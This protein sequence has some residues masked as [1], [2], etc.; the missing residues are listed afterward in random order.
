[1]KNSTGLSSLL[2]HYKNRSYNRIVAAYF[3]QKM[4]DCIAFAA[5]AKQFNIKETQVRKA[6]ANYRNKE[7]R[8]Q[9]KAKWASK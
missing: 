7:R 9:L 1:M 3:D 5:V 6:V 2:Q 8:E 4:L